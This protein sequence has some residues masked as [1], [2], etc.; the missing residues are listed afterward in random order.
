MSSDVLNFNKPCRVCRRRKVRCDKKQ[1]CNNCVRHGVQCVYEAPPESAMSQQL[2]QKR[3]ERLERIVEDLIASSIPDSA[4]QLSQRSSCPSGNSP[5]SSPGLG[6]DTPADNESHIFRPGNSD[7]M[8]PHPSMSIDHLIYEPCH[9][10]INFDNSADDE[11]WNWPLNPMSAKPRN[12]SYFHLPTCKEDVLMNLFFDHVEPFIRISRKGHYWQMVADY[13]QGN[14]ISAGEVEALL[15]A[16]QYITATVLPASIIQEQIGVARSELSNQLQQKTELTLQ[17]A[18]LM[19]SRNTILFNALLYYITCQFHTGNAEVGSGL[20]GL[21]ASIA[22]RI[23]IQRDPAY[24]GCGPWIAEMR[25][26]MWGH[27][28]TLDA[29]FANIDG[30]ES[31]MLTI[32]DVHQSHN[33]NDADWKVSTV[34]GT[35]PGPRDGEGFSDATVPLIRR[36]LSKACHNLFKAQGTI[37]NCKD[38]VAIVDETEKYLRCKFIQ[39][40]DGSN[41]M[42]LV[43]THWYNAMIKSLHVLILYFHASPS[44]VKLQCHVFEQLQGR[45]YDDCLACLEELDCGEKAAI[46]NHW[47]WAFRWPIPIHCIAGLLLGLARRPDHGDTDRAWK[48]IDV[49]FQRY[50]N[51]DISVAEV[52]AWN[53][54]EN[55]C[56]QAMLKHPNRAHEGRSYVERIHKT[57]PVTAWEP[58]RSDAVSYEGMGFS[59][60]DE[61][62]RQSNLSH[63]FLGEGMDSGFSTGDIEALFFNLDKDSEF[64]PTDF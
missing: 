26:R 34:V 53:S 46:S 24:Y 27:I 37:S 45:L 51:E 11:I 33:A 22:R 20:L 59:G 38:L 16:T 43:I 8:G 44:K 6:S 57:A 54:V 13:R 60:L 39:H 19:R 9:L 31:V 49:V 41:L 18:D 29:Q 58:H 25:R 42:Q 47:Q 55:L 50:N 28:A 62:I 14:C 32:G 10:N 21:A 63:R 48:Q 15:S 35:D 5:F 3:V 36:E 64:L 56:D 4:L 17:R 40:F 12:T 7:H 1:P 23:G 2:L 52:L 30:L 61:N